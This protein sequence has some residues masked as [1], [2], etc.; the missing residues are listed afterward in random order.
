MKAVQLNITGKTAVAWKPLLLY[1][2]G[3]N[4]RPV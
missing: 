2:E 4:A 1:V 3:E